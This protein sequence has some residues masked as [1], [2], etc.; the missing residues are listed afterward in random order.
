[1]DQTYSF[2]ASEPGERL[3]VHIESRPR[4]GVATAG[5]NGAEVGTGAACPSPKTFDA[6]LSLRRRELSRP[7]MLGLLARYPAMSLQVVAKIYGQAARLKLKGAN[8]HP[9]PGAEVAS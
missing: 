1:M 6:T 2:A 8:Y 9:H 3:Q 7:L 4:E 5:S